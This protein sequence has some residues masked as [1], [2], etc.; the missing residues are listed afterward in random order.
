ML[1]IKEQNILIVGSKGNRHV[2]M[3]DFGSM[4]RKE[5]LA[6]YTCRS[7]MTLE[8]SSHDPDMIPEELKQIKNHFRKNQHSYETWVRG[9]GEYGEGTDTALLAAILFRRIFGRAPKKNEISPAWQFAENDFSNTKATLSNT[10]E[11]LERIFR[12]ALAV[13][14]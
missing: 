11:L 13:K 2:M 10:K 6:N 9:L 1:E 5:D 3:F 8:F 4:V 12:N 7:G 14:M